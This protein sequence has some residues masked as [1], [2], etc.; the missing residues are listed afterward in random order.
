LLSRPVFPAVMSRDR[1]QLLLRCWHFADND[2]APDRN[3]ENYSRLF[4]IEPLIKSLSRTFEF[5]YTQDIN[6][7]L[8]EELG[9]YSQKGVRP[10]SHVRR[11]TLFLRLRRLFTK[12]SYSCRKP[13]VNSTTGVRLSYCLHKV[14]WNAI[15]ILLPLVL[16]S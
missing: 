11:S 1:F 4:K 9:F 2:C 3:C 10:I 12:R 13:T 6:L 5:V 7:S 16:I 15:N 14:H 8:D